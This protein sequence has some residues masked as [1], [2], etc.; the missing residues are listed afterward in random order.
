ML[1]DTYVALWAITDNPLLSLKARDILLA[2]CTHLW[3]STANLW[4]IAIKLSLG[5]GAVP[6]LREE[7]L[8]FFRQTG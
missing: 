6:V 8:G 1:L 3:V 2:S 4:E 7:A 5:R